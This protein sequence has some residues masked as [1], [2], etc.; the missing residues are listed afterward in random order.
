M[1][2]PAM[3]IAATGLKLAA[4][5]LIKS[6]NKIT[7]GATK[8]LGLLRPF[9]VAAPRLWQSHAHN[10]ADSK[11]MPSKESGMDS[12]RFACGHWRAHVGCLDPF[13]HARAQEITDVANSDAMLKR[14]R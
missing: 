2:Q 3:R 13:Q 5:C 7:S 12:R 14:Q 10:A 6:V 4:F 11:P 8:S 1:K 9:D